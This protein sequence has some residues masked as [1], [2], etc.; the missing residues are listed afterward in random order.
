MQQ[1]PRLILLAACLVLSCG[2]TQQT[3]A[4]A[5]P[6]VNLGFTSFLDGGPPAGPGLYYQ[7]YAQYFS[8]HKFRD[9]HGN[10]LNYDVDVF[11]SLNQFIYQSDQPVLL[12]GKW[13]ADLIIPFVSI[14][15]EGA[16]PPLRANDSGLGDILF[17]PFI[18]WDPVMGENGPVFMQRVEF[19]LIFPTGKYDHNHELNPGSNVFSFNPYYACTWFFAPGWTA[20]T[21]IHYLWNDENDDPS[22][23]LYPGA[24]NVQ[25]G[26]AIHANFAVAYAVVPDKLRVGLNGYYLEQITDSKVDGVSRFGHER[27][28]GLGPGAVWHIS[29]DNHVFFNLYFESQVENRPEG[30]RGQVRWTHHF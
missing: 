20:S 16:I 30:I 12:D 10:E 3:L 5:L 21:R 17:G 25:P 6:S 9:A 11:V 19:Q 23:R 15:G 4:Q 24:D 14:D 18:Q 2:V 26:Q 8:S 28:L 13:G 29:R 1:R 27:V 7:Q 22:N